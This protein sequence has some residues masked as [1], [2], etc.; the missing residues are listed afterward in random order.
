MPLS[1]FCVFL[2]PDLSLGRPLL[3]IE[4]AAS[5]SDACLPSC[6]AFLHSTVSAHFVFPSEDL[7]P[8]THFPLCQPEP[9]F[10]SLRGTGGSCCAGCVS[11]C[12]AALGSG[13]CYRFQRNV[14]DLS[15]QWRFANL[16]NNAKL[17]MVPASRS[18]EGPENMVGALGPA[19]RAA[20]HS[21]PW[22]V[23]CGQLRSRVLAPMFAFLGP[24]Q[25]HF[26]LDDGK[27]AEGAWGLAVL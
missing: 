24:G 1:C 8:G 19:S 26:H 15:L 3:P 16:P 9:R 12:T 7:S 14:L 4:G 21:S 23:G 25:S 13:L 6:A 2:F 17:E 5:P 10:H 11:I 22:A 27:C 20:S 18:R